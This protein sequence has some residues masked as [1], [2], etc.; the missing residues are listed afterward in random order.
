[1]ERIVILVILIALL[2]IHLFVPH[3]LAFLGFYYLPILLYLIS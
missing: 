2:V 3:K 1:M